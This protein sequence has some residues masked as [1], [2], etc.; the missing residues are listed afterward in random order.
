[1]ITPQKLVIRSFQL[2]RSSTPTIWF[3]SSMS[4]S[5]RTPR[6]RRAAD[7]HGEQLLHSQKNSHG[8]V[9][10]DRDRVG[11]RVSNE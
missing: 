8:D 11:S 1:M 3:Y 5:T 2:L 10:Y 4:K 7:L 9:L 6:G